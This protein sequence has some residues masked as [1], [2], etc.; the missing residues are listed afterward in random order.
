MKTRFLNS[1]TTCG[2]CLDKIQIQGSIDSCS[3]EFCFECIKTWSQTQNTCPLCI[4]RFTK[5]KQKAKRVVYVKSKADAEID[6]KTNDQSSVY[7]SLAE[8]LIRIGWIQG[9]DFVIIRRP[10]D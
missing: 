1:A 5:I 2:I 8:Y 6:V 10:D 9:R 4:K 7:L 3:H